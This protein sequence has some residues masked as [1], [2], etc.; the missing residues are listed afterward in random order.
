MSILPGVLGILLALN[1]LGGILYGSHVRS[2]MQQRSA[3][4]TG[5]VDAP[6]SITE[7][8]RAGRGPDVVHYTFAVNGTTFTGLSDVPA[9]LARGLQSSNIVSIRYLPSDPKI[10]HPATWEWSM[11][12]EWLM[13]VI[14][15][16]F[17]MAVDWPA[18]SFVRSR[19]V[20][21]WGNPAPGT[22]TACRTDGRGS[23]RV[24]YEFRATT[25]EIFKGND[26]SSSREIGT[27]VWV[28]YLPASP[29][30]NALYPSVT[31]Y[32]EQ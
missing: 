28:L 27:P 8:H 14:L 18:L 2:E 32:V 26:Y 29:K 24:N 20:V 1:L 3:L 25:G 21:A 19:Q 23:T 5:G 17:G 9:D 6:G 16:G 10:N 13:I 31:F 22:V 11:S 7:L 12:S 4:S 30:R 15:L